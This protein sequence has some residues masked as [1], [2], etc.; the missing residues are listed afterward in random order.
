MHTSRTSPSQT[1]TH[2][3]V[4]VI[5]GGL[6]V[7]QPLFANM[8]GHALWQVAGGRAWKRRCDGAGHWPNP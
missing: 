1:A 4:S 2:D 6:R 5:V 3:H 8:C 7:L